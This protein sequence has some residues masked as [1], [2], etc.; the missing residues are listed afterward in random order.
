MLDC[1]GHVSGSHLRRDDLDVSLAAL[2]V[3]R[4]RNV[5]LVPAVKTG[6]AALT[7]HRLLGGQPR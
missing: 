7:E 2:T 1:A 5:G 3:A 6:A 4:P